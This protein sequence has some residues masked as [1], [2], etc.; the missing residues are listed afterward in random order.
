M[1]K[2]AVV[3]ASVAGLLASAHAAGQACSPETVNTLEASW[4][5]GTDALTGATDYGFPQAQVPALL[6]QLEKYLVP[7]KA[8]LADPK[9][10]EL[11]SHKLVSYEP[12]VPKGPQPHVLVVELR[13]YKCTGGAVSTSTEAA[14]EAE[15]EVNR[16]ARLLGRTPVKLGGKEVF[17]LAWAVGEVHGHPLY[18]VPLS[19]TP[20]ISSHS[21]ELA[22]LLTRDG[23]L[24]FRY[25]TRAEVLDYLGQQLEKL[26]KDALAKAPKPKSKKKKGEP[27]PELEAA[28]AKVTAPFDVGLARL[29]AVRGGLTAEE[30]A[31]P[32]SVLP[33]ALVA[34]AVTDTW[35]FTDP[36]ADRS[37]VCTSSCRH[38]EQVVTIDPGYLNKAL[39]RTAPQFLLVTFAWKP[40]AARPDPALRDAFFERLDVAALTATLR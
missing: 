14:G 9:G 6:A 8:A 21:T 5:K 20:G 37:H 15:V 13:D 30:L 18:E 29:A 23:K 1:R 33:G 39:P 4:G 10:F 12:M 17:Q 19:A 22:L 35:S 11:K 31:L 36:K 3:C 34:Q 40:T 27:D 24:P 26:R 25:V 16:L 32:A 28:L 38:G 7:V 2:A